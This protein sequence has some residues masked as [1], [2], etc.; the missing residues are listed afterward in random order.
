MRQ[1]AQ[2]FRATA[3]TQR[4]L[5]AAQAAVAPIAGTHVFDWN[6]VS[7]HRRSDVVRVSVEALP[8]PQRDG[9]IVTPLADCFGV[10]GDWDCKVSLVRSLHTQVMV[11]GVERRVVLLIGEG[12][13]P[14]EAAALAQR[15]YE[16]LPRLEQAD[17]CPGAAGSADSLGALRQAFMPRVRPLPLVVDRDESTIYVR[18]ISFHLNFDRSDTPSRHEFQCW[19]YRP[20]W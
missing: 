17:A 18:S 2:A 1:D 8:E 4:E 10:R 7:A 9:S 11:D 3:L 19:S 5:A 16:V 15:A 14:G 6:T 13:A 20:L 12:L